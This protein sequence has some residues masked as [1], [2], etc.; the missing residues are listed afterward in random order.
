MDSR[1]EVWLVVLEVV[2]DAI[3]LLK[4]TKSLIGVGRC[5]ALVDMAGM[6]GERYAW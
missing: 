5:T 1:R 3:E 2:G 6:M 4:R